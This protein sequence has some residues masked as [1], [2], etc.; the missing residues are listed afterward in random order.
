[1]ADHD[2]PAVPGATRRTVHREGVDLSVLDAGEGTPVVLAHG[3]PELAWSW[4]H[5]IPALADAGCRVLAADGRGYG[6]TTAPATYTLGQPRCH[7]L[8]YFT[9]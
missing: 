9:G 6:R 8:A 1:M 4:R 2:P 7:A 3:F 5:Q